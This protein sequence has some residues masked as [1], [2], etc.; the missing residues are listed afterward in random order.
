MHR[1]TLDPTQC[2]EEYGCV[3]ISTVSFH[4]DRD[5]KIHLYRSIQVHVPKLHSPFLN[6]RPQMFA[7]SFPLYSV[8]ND[9]VHLLSLRSWNIVWLPLHARQWRFRWN[10]PVCPR[11]DFF[12]PQCLSRFRVSRLCK[13]RYLTI[14]PSHGLHFNNKH[15]LF[16]V[17]FTLH[18]GITHTT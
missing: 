2:F 12:L 13:S 15:T 1:R 16:E 11:K 14:S 7:A 17:E 5:L 4:R 9:T 6:F 18:S 8:F 3:V 10:D